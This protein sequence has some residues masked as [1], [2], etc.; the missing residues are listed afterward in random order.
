M[1]APS[2]PPE[3]QRHYAALRELVR[4]EEGRTDVLPGVTVHGMDIGKWLARQQTPKVWQAL[5]DGQCERLEQLGIVPPAPEPTEPAKESI[6]PVSAFKRSI[7]ALAQYKLVE[8]VGLC[9]RSART[10]SVTVPRRHVETFVVNG[11][12]HAVKLGVFLSNTKSRRAKLTPDKLATLVG[13]GLQWAGGRRHTA[14]N[15]PL[16]PPLWRVSNRWLL[17][18]AVNRDDFRRGGPASPLDVTPSGDVAGPPRRTPPL[19][20]SSSTHCGCRAGRHSRP[21]FL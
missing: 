3:W 4:D 5:P 18:M 20:T 11:Q 16:Q 2:W 6:A 19:L 7:T 13:L 10:G 8:P 17:T 21:A 14:S 15:K 1:S 9:V 12:E